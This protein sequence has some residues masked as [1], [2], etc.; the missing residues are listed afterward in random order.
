MR[1]RLLVASLVALAVTGASYGVVMTA[2]ARPV[3]GTHCETF[4][5]DNYWRADVS[6]LPVDPRSKA[7]LSHMST[8]VDLHPDFGPSFGHGPNYGI[9][10]TVVGAAHPRVRVHF[11]YARESDHVRYP[12]GRDTRIEGGRSSSGDRH[13]IVVDKSTCRLYE[14]FATRQR[15]GR[16]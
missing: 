5:A 8:G 14:T 13:A 12:L 4:P 15:N 3:A 6:H 10:I 11:H 2:D 7:W 16:W 1:T 9:P